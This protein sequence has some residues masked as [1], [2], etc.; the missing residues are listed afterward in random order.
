MKRKY[1][2]PG[3]VK[4]ELN[5]TCLQCRKV[6]RTPQGLCGHL[7]KHHHIDVFSIT[8]GEDWALTKR[9]AK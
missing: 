4:E 2:R 5:F 7:S 8:Y 3:D 1:D 9:E 6:F